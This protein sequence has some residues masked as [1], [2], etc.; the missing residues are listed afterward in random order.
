MDDIEI[1]VEDIKV[2]EVEVVVGP[3]EEVSASQSSFC[4]PSTLEVD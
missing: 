1:K 4:F 3:A 2:E